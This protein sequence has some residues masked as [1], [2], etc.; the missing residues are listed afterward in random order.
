[1]IGDCAGFLG[2]GEYAIQVGNCNKEL[3]IGPWIIQRTDLKDHSHIIINH[4]SLI[5]NHKLLI[6]KV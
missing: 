4:K 6:K 5:I 3:T 2:N 1:M